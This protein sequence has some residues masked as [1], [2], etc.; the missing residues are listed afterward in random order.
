MKKNEILKWGILCLFILSLSVVHFVGAA[1]KTPYKVGVSLDVTGPAS[2][3]G[4]PERNTLVMIEERVN[5]EGG[6]NGHPLKLIIYDNATDTSKHVMNLKRLI[7]Q[8]KVCAILGGSTSGVSLAGIPVVEKAQIPNICF[9]ASIKVVEP[10]KKWVFKTLKTDKTS[11]SAGLVYGKKLGFKKVAFMHGDTSA[12]ISA[13]DEFEKL[14]PQMGFTVVGI[15]AFGDKE[16]DMTSQ[17]T[18]IRA[19]NPDFIF[20]YPASPAGSAISKNW[21]ML[22]IKARLMQ[23]TGYASQEYIDLAGEAGNGVLVTS[24]R[25]IISDQIPFWSPYK[26]VLELYKNSYMEKYKGIKVNEF[27]GH[28]WDGMMVL[29]MALEKSGDDPAKIRDNIE[30]TK[31]FFGVNG[32]YKFSPTDHCGLGPDSCVIVEVQNQKFKLLD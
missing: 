6:I 32:L 14:A 2:F 8:D 3:L 9:A 7:E 5:R 28:A 13:L 15:E 17:L 20:A 21:K 30:N 24:G 29:L 22:G 31:N 1:E 27:G 4:E 25:F 12:G 19:K 10:V 26:P 11:I 23:G 18:K 16:T